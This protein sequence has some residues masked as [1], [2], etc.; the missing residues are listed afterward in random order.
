[1][2]EETK[3]ST[4]ITKVEGHFSGIMKKTIKPTDKKDTILDL[5]LK[6]L[7]EIRTDVSELKQDVTD[8][9]VR[10]TNLEKDVAEL[11]QDVA[12]IKRCPTI[13]KELAAL[14]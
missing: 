12:D 13:Q 5:I 8:I 9:K 4:T 1:I 7:K 6:E 11:K 10:V 14:S 3:S 2:D